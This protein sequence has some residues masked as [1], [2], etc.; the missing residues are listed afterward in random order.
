[1]PSEKTLRRTTRLRAL[2]DTSRLDFIMEAHDGLSAKVA[3]EAGFPA[4]WASG[5]AISASLGVRDNNEASWTQVLEVAEFMADA[6]S[7]PIL[8]DGDTGF[9][10]FNNLRRVV[11]KLGERGLAGICIEDK[12]F[13]KTNSFLRGERQPLADIAEFCGKIKAGKDAQTDPDFVLVARTEAF[14][15]GHGLE[16]ALLRA[17]AYREA[18]ADAVIVHS[19]RSR[20]DEVI[21]FL[22]AW[23][24]RHPVILIPTKYHATP[25]EVFARHKVAALIWANHLLRASLSAMQAAAARIARERSVTGVEE[26]IAPLKEVFRLQ[27]DDELCE[28]ESR[29]LAPGPRRSAVIL[30]ATRGSEALHSLTREVPKALLR[31]GGVALLDRMCASLRLLGVND[32]AV[33][34]GYRKE[35]VDRPGLTRVDNDAWQ[36]TGEVGSLCLARAE[37][38]GPCVIAFGDI[39]CRRHI[40][41]SLFEDDGDLVLSADRAVR[42]ESGPSPRPRDLVRFAGP[43]PR[44]FME[45]RAKVAGAAFSSDFASFDAEWTGLLKCSARGAQVL[46]AWLADAAARPDGP[47]LALI[48]M[49]ADL[50]SK[51][52]PVGAQVFTGGW[53]TI[54]SAVDLADAGNL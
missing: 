9:G 27:G 12:V 45:E 54:E 26:T 4:V 19:A 8:V 25:T 7:V 40:L 43:A 47:R 14:I 16:G 31:V 32:I 20:P 21:A 42:S 49:I 30:A 1:M 38:R 29:Y 23:G 22:E 13:P 34:A 10:N 41:Q 36:S 6:T 2:L 17:E 53:T 11:R 52:H 35:A 24:N 3:G 46:Q 33:V 18:G 37:L 15:A 50:V 39:L 44:D 48:D 28:A 5:L 51:G